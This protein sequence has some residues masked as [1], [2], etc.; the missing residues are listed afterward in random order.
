MIEIHPVALGVLLSIEFACGF[1]LC[2][3]G[4]RYDKSRHENEDETQP[5][6]SPDDFPRIYAA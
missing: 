1:F 2:W 5:P 4:S 6:D 3:A